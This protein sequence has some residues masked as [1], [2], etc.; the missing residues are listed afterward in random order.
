M[1]DLPTLKSEFSTLQTL[2][3]E[4]QSWNYHELSYSVYDLNH[5]LTL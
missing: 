3:F 2:N 5:D 4:D 1:L